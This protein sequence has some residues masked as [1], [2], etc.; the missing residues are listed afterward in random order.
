MSAPVPLPAGPPDATPDDIKDAFS[1]AK[2]YFRS[3]ATRPYEWRIGQLKALRALAW[4]NQDAINQAGY[5]D[6]RRP[7]CVSPRTPGGAMLVPPCPIHDLMVFVRF[8]R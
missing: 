2:A 6:M 7:K 3:G 5:A 8:M 4:D 1:S